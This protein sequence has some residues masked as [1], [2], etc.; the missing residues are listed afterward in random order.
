MDYYVGVA[1]LTY[2]PRTTKRKTTE[3]TEEAPTKN[4]RKGRED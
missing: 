3:H 2:N 4:A 1:S